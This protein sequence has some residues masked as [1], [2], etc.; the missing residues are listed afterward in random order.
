M[1][2]VW[3]ELVETF[4][5]FKKAL[6]GPRANLPGLRERIMCLRATGQLVVIQTV[7]LGL[8][9]DMTLKDIIEG[10]N[11]LSWEMDNPL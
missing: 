8:K 5:P 4:A 2:S 3:R 10:L 6:S 7:Q 9:H 1:V 11:K